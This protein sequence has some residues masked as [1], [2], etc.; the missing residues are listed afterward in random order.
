MESVVKLVVN[1]VKSE[2]MYDIKETIDDY[3]MDEKEYNN[4]FKDI[5]FGESNEATYD[6]E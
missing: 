4:L 1:K 3:K 6:N 2:L 5:I